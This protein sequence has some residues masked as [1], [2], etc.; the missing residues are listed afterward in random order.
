VCVCVCVCVFSK[1][2][3]MGMCFCVGLLVSVHVFVLVPRCMYVYLDV[4]TTSVLLL[5]CGSV[6]AEAEAREGWAFASANY[7]VLPECSPVRN[8]IKCPPANPAGAPCSYR[9]K[10]TSPLQTSRK[11]LVSIQ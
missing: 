6:C 2:S 4:C 5:M 10:S 11:L 3:Y 9:I 7:P 1:F 8:N